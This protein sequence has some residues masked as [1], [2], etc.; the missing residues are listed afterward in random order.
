M[1]KEILL[2]NEAI[3]LGLLEGGCNLISGYPGTPSSEIL[4]FAAKLNEKFKLNRFVEWS[5]NEKCALELAHGNSMCGGYS[6]VTMKQVGLNVAMDP[7]MNIA[8]IGFKGA[9]TLVVADDPGPYSSQTEQDTRFFCMGAKV[10]VFD[11]SSPNE[12]RVFAKQSLSL[13]K[14][15][16]IPVV[17]RLTG[18]TAHGKENIEYDEIKPVE[19][20]IFFEKNPFRWAAIPRFRYLQHVEL[21]KKIEKISKISP[22]ILKKFNKNNKKLIITSG[23]CYAHTIDALNYLKATSVDVLKINMPYPINPEIREVLKNYPKILIIEEMMPVIEYQILKFKN[24]V[25]G[26]LDKTIPQEGELGI[27]IVTEIIANFFEL[28]NLKFEKFEKKSKKPQLC[29]GCPHRSSFYAIKKAFKNGIFPSDIGCYTLGLNMK[30]VDTCLCMG[31]TINHASGIYHSYKKANKEVP[32]IVATIGDS[33]FYHSGTSPLINAVYHKSAFVLVILDNGTTAMTGFQPTPESGKLYSGNG[34]K[35]SL[36]NLIKGCGI[37]KI[38]VIN[39]NEIDLMIKKLKECWEYSIKNE[40]IS[41]IIAKAPCIL[42]LKKE[43]GYKFIKVN[44]IEDK[45]TGC[46]VCTDQ[47]QCPAIIFNEKTKKAQIDYSICT[48]CGVCTTI[49]KFNAIKEY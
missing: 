34:N 48:G 17:I 38:E 27:H 46:K 15:F 12:A 25:S 7:F 40:K 19:H 3:A 2:G 21:N 9:L 23:C 13:S 29:P 32:P 6:A 1:I 35:V 11:P 8:Y 33:T 43:K 26:R 47:F 18:R 44:I 4:P 37:E 49:C 24:N 22:F 30:A 5:V 20:N 16:E 31:A 45:C 14:Q 42:L 41:V 10:P 28:K 36:K 39:P